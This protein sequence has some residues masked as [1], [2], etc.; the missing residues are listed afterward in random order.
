MCVCVCVCDLL[1]A[2]VGELL[3]DGSLSLIEQHLRTKDKHMNTEH[4]L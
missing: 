2:Q 4:L 1:C 3:A